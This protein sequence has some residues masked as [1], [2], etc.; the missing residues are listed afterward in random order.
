[1]A[2]TRPPARRLA[3]ALAL[4]C[5]GLAAARAQPEPYLLL[6]GPSSRTTYRFAVGETLEWRLRGEPEAF[7]ATIARLFP[8]SNA[9]QLEGLLLSVD[10][11]AGVR[12]ERRGAGLRTYLR[13]QGIAN[14]AFLGGGVA[15]SEEIRDRQAGFVAVAAAVSGAMVLAGSVNRHARREIGPRYLLSVAGGD[16]RVG[17]DPER[18]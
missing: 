13:F 3:L 12:H 2:Q 16:L 1:M 18:G 10:S 8:E 17:D 11:I 15:F 6:Q 4:A 7:T 14:L 5:L 9:I